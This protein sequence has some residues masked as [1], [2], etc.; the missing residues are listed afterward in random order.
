MLFFKVHWSRNGS[1]KNTL[2]TSEQGAAPDLPQ[3]RP[4]F[5]FISL[6]ASSLYCGA[7]RNGSV[8]LTTMTV[9]RY[10]F[11]GVNE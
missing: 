10:A 4:S 11:G 3:L 1:E 6:R 8:K 7:R 5:Q 2:T 9:K